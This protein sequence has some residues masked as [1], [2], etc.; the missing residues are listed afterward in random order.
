MAGNRPAGKVLPGLRHAVQLEPLP[1]PLPS[2]GA[3]RCGAFSLPGP[4][5]RSFARVAAMSGAVADVAVQ[6]LKRAA[7]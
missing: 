4:L 3:V 2:S 6:L 1:W 7:R 5:R